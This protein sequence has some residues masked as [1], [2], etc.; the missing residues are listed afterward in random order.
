MRRGGLEPEASPPPAGPSGK[1]VTVGF[2]PV[3][4]GH[5]LES[6]ARSIGSMPRVLLTDT[7]TDDTGQVIT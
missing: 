5:I 1:N 6:L 3:Q 4:P 7:R 2:E